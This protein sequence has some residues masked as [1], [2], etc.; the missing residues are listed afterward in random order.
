MKAR[1]YLS[2]LTYTYDPYQE[3]KISTNYYTKWLKK[4]I[5]NILTNKIREAQIFFRKNLKFTTYT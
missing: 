5:K 4:K 2:L 3:T 1:N